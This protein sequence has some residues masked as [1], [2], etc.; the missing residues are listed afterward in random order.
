MIWSGTSAVGAVHVI[1]FVF[2]YDDGFEQDVAEFI[3]TSPLHVPSEGH[4]ITL[5]DVRVT[6]IRVEADY[7]ATADGFPCVTAEVIVVPF[8]ET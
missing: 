4:T 8:E 5:H 3:A 2:R 1:R 6:V 7:G